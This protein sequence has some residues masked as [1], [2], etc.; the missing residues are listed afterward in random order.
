V[1]AWDDDDVLRTTPYIIEP[2]APPEPNDM[3]EDRIAAL[4]RAA[5]TLVDDISEQTWLVVHAIAAGWTPEQLDAT[6]HA[7][8]CRAVGHPVGTLQIAPANGGGW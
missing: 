1:T 4:W 8:W 7:G 2:E 5:A 3:D 6:A